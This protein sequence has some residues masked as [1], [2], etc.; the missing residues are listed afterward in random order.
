MPIDRVIHGGGI[1]QK[2]EV[3]NQ[4]YANVL[5]KPVLVPERPI[6]S[7]GSAIF[8]SLAAGLHPTIE[9]AQRALC[10]SY[11]VVEPQP[12]AVGVYEE[13]YTLY[14]RLYFGLG[15]PDS[16]AIVTGDLLP[17]LRRIASEARR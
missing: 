8:A 6:T 10:P 17:T 5:N 14:R 9:A 7:L 12:Q 15:V 2:N 11:V 4:V 16:S 13:L 3:L 1:P